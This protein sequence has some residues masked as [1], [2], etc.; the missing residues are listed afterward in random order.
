MNRRSLFAA[1]LAS[2]QIE[3]F[4]LQDHTVAACTDRIARSFGIPLIRGGPISDS[5]TAKVARDPYIRKAL[6]S[7][8]IRGLQLELFFTY[9]R[10]SLIRLASETVDSD[11]LVLFSA[12]AQQCFINEY[13]YLIGDDEALQIAKWREL[14]EERMAAGNSIEPFILVAVAAYLPLYSLSTPERLFKQKWSPAI[15]ELLTQQ[16]RE[17]LEEIRERNSIPA[18]TPIVDSTSLQVRHQYEQN[19]YPRWTK[20]PPVGRRDPKEMDVLIAG[21]GTGKH[22]FDVAVQNPKARV[23]AIDISVA[24]LAYA[25]RKVREERLVNIEFA[26]ADILELGAIGR[27]FDHIEAVGVLHHLAD[28]KTGWRVLLSLLRPGGTMHVG[29]YSQ[30]ARRAV[31]EARSIISREGYEPTADGIRAMRRMIMRD[32]SRWKA[33][34]GFSDFYCM[35][36][37]RDLLFNVME[38]RFAVSDIAEFLNDNKLT[39]LGFELPA[40][41]NERFQQQYQG[42]LL[43]LDCWQLF[44]LNQ[45]NT[46][47]FMYQFTVSKQRT[48]I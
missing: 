40:D 19:P 8:L 3:H 22:I 46:F 39:F 6:Q 12:L 26:Q 20:L 24:S 33:I 35:S 16:I 14:I 42:R 32:D 28:P 30:L 44:E 4:I 34:T 13:V 27:V 25:K 15:V 48:A 18:I 10:K 38:H 7:T 47:R 31:V 41:V 5:E 21:C 37:C 1:A 36:G 43:D 17:P 2:D 23:L 9:L 45:P 11:I 29:L